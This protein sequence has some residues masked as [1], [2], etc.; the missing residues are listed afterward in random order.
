MARL[1]RTGKAKKNSAAAQRFP[2]KR[3]RPTTTL[4]RVQIPARPL[5]E[6]PAIATPSPPV[7]LPVPIA[8][9]RRR[10]ES[11]PI[12]AIGASAGGVEAF[13]KF[14]SRMPADTGMAFVLIPHLDPTHKSLMV[15]LLAKETPMPVLEALHGTLVRAN[16]V[17]VIPPNRYLA[18][19]RRRLVLSQ[20]PE[21][22][23]GQTAIDSA[24]SSLAFDQKENAIGIVLSGTGSHGTAGLKEI[25]AAGGIVLVQEPSTARYEQMPRSALNA[26][27]PVDFVLPPEDMPAALSAYAQQTSQHHAD[28][29]QALDAA[30]H[31]TLRLILALLQVRTKSDFR[32]YRKNMVWRRIQRRMALLRIEPVDKYVERLQQDT[33]ELEALRRDLLI[34]VTTFFREPEAFNVLAAQV[35]PDL[36]RHASVD[37]PVRV[38]VPACSTGEEAYSIAILLIEQFRKAHKEVYLQMFATDVEEDSLKIARRGIYPDSIVAAVSPELLQRFFLRAEPHH[39]QVGKQLREAVVFAPQNLIGDPPFSKLDLISCR[40]ALMYLEP[41]MQAKVISLLHFALN[42]Q[43]YLLLGPAESLGETADLFEPISK[44]WR[45]YRKSGTAQPELRSFAMNSASPRRAFP[46]PFPPLSRAVAG[47]GALMQRLLLDEFA[48]AA[49][50]INHKYQILSVQGPVVKYLQIP[51]GELTHDLLAMA[52]ESL[53]AAIRTAC[54]K[55]IRRG[56]RVRDTNARVRRDRHYVPCSVSVRPIIRGAQAEPLLLVLFEDAVARTPARLTRRSRASR[57][58]DSSATRR[59]VEELRVT[60][61]DLQRTISEWESTNE[62]LKASNEEILS[63]NEELQSANEE[64]ES[65]KEELQSLN[66]EL[67]TVNNQLEEKINDLDAANTDLTNLV[68]ATNI[69]IV[70]LDSELRIRRFTA[71]AG[72]LLHLLP[73]DVGRPLLQLAPKF[74]DDRLIQDAQAVLKKGDSAESEIL[75]SENRSYLRRILPYRA[76]QG[77]L[78]VVVS[79]IDVTERVQAEAQARRMAGV[80]RDT[81]DA[82]TVMDLEGHITAWNRG[83]ESLYGYT[84]G[85]ALKMSVADLAT[86]QS[87]GQTLEVVRRSAHD[88]AVPPFEAQRRTSDGRVIEVWTTVTPL[89]NTA[90]K[91]IA[92]AMTERDITL[93]RRADQEI[94]ALNTR[95]EKRIDARARAL[96]ASE[97]RMRAI[98]DASADAMIA[99]DS[100]GTIITFNQSA[101]ELFGYSTAEAVGQNV[102]M[103]MPPSVS[104]EHDGYLSRYVKTRE[105][106]IIGKPRELDGRRK[107]G[108]IFPIR[109]SIKEV[110]DQDLF[111]GCVQ[112]R[113]A[114][115]ALQEE[116]LS[117]AALEQQRI[118]QELHD[119]TQQELTGLGLLAQTLSDAI[120]HGAGEAT[121]ALAARLARGI[122]ETNTHVRALSRGLIPV[123]VDADTLPAALRELARNTQELSRLTCHFEGPGPVSLPDSNMATHLYRIAQ[124]AVGNAVRHAKADAISIRLAH[125]DDDLVLE[126]RDNGVGFDARKRPHEGVGLRLMEHRCAVVGGRFSVKSQKGGGTT[127]TCAIPR[128]GRVADEPRRQPH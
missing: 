114:A 57:A 36:V 20:P 83:A 72:K 2:A 26:G 22:H 63:M 128:P 100:T 29:P 61:E 99:I 12:V 88:E 34:G 54:E 112:D 27:I 67:T 82:I 28:Q 115:K 46:E 84:E 56:T 78:G 124:E 25:K 3:R 80:L 49:V 41:D 91:S 87:L 104:A 125:V 31:E 126:I 77:P 110:P 24:L 6:Q 64:L 120:A 53:R 108:L 117:I 38:S 60:R 48:P 14:F 62:E 92:L 69:A 101:S 11:F 4:R 86:D 7:A 106:H 47:G 35:L 118:G 21:T 79:F 90:G 32:Y 116:V 15:D 42:A 19:K 59:L 109:L 65:S 113:T 71:P 74:T 16:H 17:Y 70:F 119:G 89:R 98:L 94:R 55:A 73:A 102:R 97:Q 30:M 95:L 85:K 76:S 33:G 111:V 37:V 52:R 96:E 5:I 18:I 123:P 43:G 44:K 121:G 1:R 51:P 45:I 10:P 40:N 58:S 9:P 127:V 23:A 105:P 103:L 75:S 8:S 107:D 39:Y 93:R 68:G 50:L 13:K 81:G 122:A 66:E